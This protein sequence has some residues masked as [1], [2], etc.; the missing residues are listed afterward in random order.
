MEENFSGHP[1]VGLSCD[2]ESILKRGYVW[3]FG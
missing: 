2:Q 3:V 1:Q